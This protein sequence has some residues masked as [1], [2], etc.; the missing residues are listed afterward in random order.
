ML[1]V[2]KSLGTV[3][4]GDCNS[5]RW[6]EQSFIGH[7]GHWD[8]HDPAAGKECAKTWQEEEKKKKI[9]PHNRMKVPE[10]EIDS[11]HFETSMERLAREFSAGISSGEIQRMDAHTATMV[12]SV[13]RCAEVLPGT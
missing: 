10:K 9:P 8:L 7:S 2:S 11:V 5:R 1:Y 12:Q 3:V 13:H 6:W 4:V